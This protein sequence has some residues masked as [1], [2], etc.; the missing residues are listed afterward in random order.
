MPRA[1]RP[2]D[3][4]QLARSLLQFIPARPPPTPVGPEIRIA[5]AADGPGPV[6]LRQC[7]HPPSRPHVAGHVRLDLRVD[8]SSCRIVDEVALDLL[9]D[10]DTP[11][12]G[13]QRESQAAEDRR[14][15]PDSACGGARPGPGLSPP[16][17]PP[18][19]LHAVSSEPRARCAAPPPRSRASAPSAPRRSG[20]ARARSSPRDPN[21]PRG[22]GAVPR[23]PCVNRA[24][25]PSDRRRRSDTGL[26]RGS[27]VYASR[28]LASAW[29]SRVS[30]S[31]AIQASSRCTA[32]V[33]RTNQ[34]CSAPRHRARGKRSRNRRTRSR[35]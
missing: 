35:S 15:A 21:G 34:R 13:R 6:D 17:R 32:V 1:L 7:R 12:E 8:L 20:T 24:C 9:E 26:S 3:L 16:A 29:R 14:P 18:C 31:C 23:R 19:V 2:L 25:A 30:S 11:L 33:P 22:S 27:K 4:A 10:H 5:V 28:P